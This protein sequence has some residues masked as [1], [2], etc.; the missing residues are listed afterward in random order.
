MRLLGGGRDDG[1]QR[2]AQVLELGL[3]RGVEQRQGADVDSVVG[4]L[5][6]DNNSGADGLAL[7]TAADAYISEE[8]LSIPE[9]G[10]LLG[11]A[12]ALAALGLCLLLVLRVVIILAGGGTRGLELGDTLGLALLGR[13]SSFGGGFGLSSSGLALLLALYLGVFGSIPGV[14]DL[15]KG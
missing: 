9:I 1:C 7:A 12:E 13:S 5:A 2:V 11:A 4:V 10:L 14:E 15:R 3:G 8:I 6:V